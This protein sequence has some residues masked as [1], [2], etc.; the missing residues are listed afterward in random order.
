MV[1]SRHAGGLSD[2]NPP[3][4]QPAARKRRGER[5]IRILSYNMFLRPLYATD[6][7]T[8]TEDDFKDER[9]EFFLR[10]V[11]VRGSGAQSVKPSHYVASLC[12]K[13]GQGRSLS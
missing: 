6:A 1:V 4:S 7:R 10:Q 13:Q 2:Y 12:S 9:L 8:R 11:E 3:A 5:L